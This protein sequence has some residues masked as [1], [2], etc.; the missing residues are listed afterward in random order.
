MLD[1]G[2]YFV[3]SMNR[4]VACSVEKITWIFSAINYVNSILDNAIKRVFRSKTNL[5]SKC[6]DKYKL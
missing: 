5:Y 1:L 3:I 2:I 4:F 6:P